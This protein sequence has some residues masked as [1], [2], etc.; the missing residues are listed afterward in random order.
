MVSTDL[1]KDA[2][3]KALVTKY[4]VV[5]PT[6]KVSN[7]ITRAEMQIGRTKF[8]FNKTTVAELSYPSHVIMYISDDAKQIVIAASQKSDMTIPFFNPDRANGHA[9]FYN[10]GLANTIHNALGW[11]PAHLYTI[12]AVA[13]FDGEIILFDLEQAFVRRKGE[14]RPKGAALRTDDVLRHYPNVSEFIQSYQQLAIAERTSAQAG[15][16][17]EEI[18]EAAYRDVDE[19]RPAACG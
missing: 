19:S 12:P 15:A 4:K 16:K 5:M 7:R 8:V 14:W 6:V 2:L 11:D 1:N 10:K 9:V 18:I 3:I 17:Q 13:C